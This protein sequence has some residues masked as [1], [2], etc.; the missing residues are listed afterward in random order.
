MFQNMSDTEP[1]TVVVKNKKV[2]PCLLIHSFTL[3]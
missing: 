1:L 3:L 2:P